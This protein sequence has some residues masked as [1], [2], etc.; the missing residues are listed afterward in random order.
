MKFL[1]NLLFIIL[2]LLPLETIRAEF[3]SS[4]YQ[5]WTL[6]LPEGFAVKDAGEDGLSYYLE[7]EFM[8]TRLA[9]RLYPENAYARNDLAMEEVLNRLNADG[10]IDGFLW[11]GRQASVASYSFQLPGNNVSQSGWGVSLTIPEKKFHIVILCYSDKDVAEDSQQFI[12]SCIDSVCIEPSDFRAPGVITSYAF[13]SEEREDVQLSIGGKKVWTTLP[14]EAR[15]EGRF[16][17]DREFSVLTLYVKQKQWKEAWQRYY[18]MIFRASYSM[19]DAAAKDIHAALYPAA[20]AENSDNANLEICRKLL[21]TVQGFS[22]NR[23][24]DKSDFNDLA[25]VLQNKGS[26]CDSRALLLCVLMEHYGVKTELFVSM[27]YSHALFGV[28]LPYKGAHISVDG[29]NYLL[30]ETTA[31][32]DMGLVAQEHGD[33]S[34][35]IEVDL[36]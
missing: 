3:F 23:R 11:R 16:V 36:P 18:R 33:T 25:G 21:G 17:I 2:V 20:L 12:L 22:Y 6:D 10:E 15:D 30:C 34:K 35:W 32:V 28:D 1:R 13:N 4:S 19:L 29:T 26:D 9:V 8:K 31:P 24:Q 14:K 27:A 5:G 7:H